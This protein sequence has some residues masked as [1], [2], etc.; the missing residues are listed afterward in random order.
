MC[1]RKLYCNNKKTRSS[2]DLDAAWR[3][4]CSYFRMIRV[5]LHLQLMCVKSVNRKQT[6]WNT[7]VHYARISSNSFS[8]VYGVYIGCNWPFLK[9]PCKGDYLVF[10]FPEY[11]FTVLLTHNIIILLFQTY[12][13]AEVGLDVHESLVPTVVSS[14]WSASRSFCCESGEGALAIN[15]IHQARSPKRKRV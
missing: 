7:S 11:S 15:W 5:E 13:N 4:N 6:L 12:V 3:A 10:Q 8:F 9:S 14:E 1:N 2:P